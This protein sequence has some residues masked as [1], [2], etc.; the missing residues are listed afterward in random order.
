MLKCGTL[1]ETLYIKNISEETPLRL[2]EHLNKLQEV[3]N[4]KQIDLQ[5][6]PDIISE[7]T[8]ELP[9]ETKELVKD[10]RTDSKEPSIKLVITSELSQDTQTDGKNSN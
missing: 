10:L 1:R 5:E 3:L 6:E 8:E 7:L 9:E 4:I 2:P